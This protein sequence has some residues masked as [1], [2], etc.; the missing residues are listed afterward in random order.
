MFMGPLWL[1]LPVM[2]KGDGRDVAS[3][4]A[5]AEARGLDRTGRHHAMPFRLPVWARG[6]L[7]RL[8]CTR[9]LVN[10]TYC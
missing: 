7:R 4:G 10:T 8:Q 9:L 2:G 5:G 3:A 6:R 1:G